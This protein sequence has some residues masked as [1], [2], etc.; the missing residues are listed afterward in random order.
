MTFY[1]FIKDKKNYLLHI[2][3]K[4]IIRHKIKYQ[5]YNFLVLCFFLSLSLISYDVLLLY[6]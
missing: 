4:K 5:N 1:L 2:V 3:S 6:V